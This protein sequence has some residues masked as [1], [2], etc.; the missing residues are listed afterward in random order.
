MPITIASNIASLGA[1][2]QL[3]KVTESLGGTFERLSSGLRINKASDDAAGLA[4]ANSLSADSRIFGQAIRNLND[5]ISA[6]SISEGALAQLSEI[7]IRQTELAEQSANG[8][9]SLQQRSAMQTEIDALSKEQT[10]IVRTTSFNGIRLLDDNS[11]AIY[12]Q[13]GR[14]DGSILSLDISDA[15]K[16]NVGTGSYGAQVTI[17]SERSG[18]DISSADVNGD[19]K[20]DLIVVSSDDDVFGVSLGNG[21]GTFAA[22]ISYAMGDAAYSITVADFNN[23]GAL[24]VATADFAGDSVSVRLNQGNG[25]FGAVTSYY[26]AT[27]L[28][29]ARYIESGDVNGDGI[30][31]LVVQRNNG[32]I[33]M[34]QGNG[35]GTFGSIVTVV[36]GATSSLSV[37]DING[38]NKAEIITGLNDAIRIYS[39]SGSGSF[40]QTASFYLGN[41]PLGNLIGDFNRDGRAD[42]FVTGG[43]LATAQV[44]LQSSDGTFSKTTQDYTSTSSTYQSG[45]NIGDYNN[46]GFLDIA[47]AEFANPGSVN[48]LYGNGDGTFSVGVSIASGLQTEGLTS[49]DFNSDGVLDI[50]TASASA[51]SDAARIHIQSTRRSGE[52]EMFNIMT[53][54]GAREVLD[55]LRTSLERV[56]QQL[57]VIGSGQSRL[58]VAINTLAVSRENYISAASRIMDVDVAQESAELTRQ[59][60][61]QQAAASVLGQANQQPQ[62]ALQLLRG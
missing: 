8:T 3:G 11:T 28:N 48:F 40:S 10:R 27:L 46:D 29:D 12:L 55:K 13:A 50:A 14:G 36:S 9:Y 58:G 30:L 24:D 61:L 59:N 7:I 57:G 41:F 31:D 19:G 42:V 22:S 53:Q 25:T 44:W 6:T 23:D 2:R 52:A 18:R 32:T 56:S 49:G 20:L 17:D 54:T 60:I 38:D 37:M 26:S 34:L 5:G 62:L 16:R 45:S 51:L 21:D 35:N 33:M 1:Q 15:M 39:H 43:G 47:R 4:I